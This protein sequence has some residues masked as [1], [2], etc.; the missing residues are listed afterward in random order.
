V[1]IPAVLSFSDCGR[2]LLALTKDWQAADGKPATLANVRTALAKLIYALSGKG[3]PDPASDQ[4]V[5][6]ESETWMEC[7]AAARAAKD[8]SDKPL[9][10]EG[11]YAVLWSPNTTNASAIGPGL[12]L[13]WPYQ[14]TSV[15]SRI[16]G[17]VIDADN[18]P[19]QL[20]LF[21]QVDES[22]AVDVGVRPS[23][24]F[25]PKAPAPVAAPA[26]A[27]ARL[28]AAA[29]VPVRASQKRPIIATLLFVLWVASFIYLGLWEWVQGS[30]GYRTWTALEANISKLDDA[31]P[32]KKCTTLT[33][34]KKLS[35]I[36]ECDKLW[37]DART[38]QKP[39]DSKKGD[40]WYGMI[41]RHFWTDAQATLLTPFLLTLVATCFLVVAA[42]LGSAKGVWFG[43]LI[44]SRNRFSLS[45]T[46][47]MAWTILLL[48]G[49][50]LT[51]AF[52][53]ILIPATLGSG[54]E[55]IPQMA[56]ALW[57]ALGV[58]LVASPYL[59]A[60]I[61]DNKEGPAVEQQS[62]SDPSLMQ[63]LVTPAKLDVNNSPS[64]ASWLDLMT[65]ETAGMENQLDVSRV[66][67]LIISG[68]LIS[69]YLMLLAKLMDSVTA[70][71]IATAFKTGQPPF[72]ELPPV[73]ETF[74]G[75]LL[76]SHGG[77]L[78]FKARKTGSDGGSAAPSQP[79]K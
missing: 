54:L 46:Q 55:F 68:L 71:T 64:Q 59:S 52:N 44:D 20:F 22:A 1:D 47:Q 50:W 48:G 3:F 37:D 76:L 60:L 17:P 40:S 45:R 62:P 11:R 75:L 79:S 15:V 25:W 70:E 24:G 49:L 74:L 32:L 43:A 78:A 63:S 26:Q 51:S 57:A 53:A 8:Q 61:L 67:H 28:D 31:N 39:P 13:N 14:P 30:I 36:A 34:K 12:P 27:V 4:L 35:W 7:L 9:P 58:N 2:I 69:I 38:A 6:Q 18:K 21:D 42:G 10:P 73:G 16:F 33:D 19:K 41:Y 72:T 56:G 65:G 29:P 66:Q 23:P 5:Q 77:Y